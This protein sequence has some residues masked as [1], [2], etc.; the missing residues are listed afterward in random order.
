MTACPASRRGII[1]AGRHTNSL[2]DKSPQA[3]HLPNRAGLVT[4][5]RRATSRRRRR[6]YSKSVASTGHLLA[7]PEQKLPVAAPGT[8]PLRSAMETSWLAAQTPLQPVGPCRAG[9][10]AEIEAHALGQALIRFRAKGQSIPP[11][12]WRHY[13]AKGLPGADRNSTN[14]ASSSMQN[15]RQPVLRELWLTVPPLAEQLGDRCPIAKEAHPLN[16][17]LLAFDREIEFLEFRPPRRHRHR[18]GPT[19]CSRRRWSTV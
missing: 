18:D 17:Q 7:R 1:L 12:W 11:I 6:V 5:M 15:I 3:L 10:Q 8:R 4:A 13:R 16:R 19:R 2:A 9:Q 14:G